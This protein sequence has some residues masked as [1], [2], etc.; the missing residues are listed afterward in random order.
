M[1]ISQN[2]KL[3]KLNLPMLEAI[4]GPLIIQNNSALTSLASL[5]HLGA[6][7]ATGKV[8]SITIPGLQVQFIP[9]CFTHALSIFP[10]PFASLVPATS[11]EGMPCMCVKSHLPAV[12]MHACALLLLCGRHN[13]LSSG[14]PQHEL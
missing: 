9:H 4:G 8:P 7:N 10:L 6:V 3:A 1:Q 12:Q 13:Q 11:R 2:P 5:E 14:R